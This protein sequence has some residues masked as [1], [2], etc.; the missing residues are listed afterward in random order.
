MPSPPQKPGQKI[1]RVRATTQARARWFGPRLGNVQAARDPWRCRPRQ[2]PGTREYWCFWPTWNVGLL[3]HE[4][5]RAGDLGDPLDE[6]LEDPH[7]QGRGG[8]GF[9][10]ELRADGEPVVAGAL[11]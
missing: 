7:V 9:G 3:G 5:H 2:E 8:L 4:L 1:N 10:V 11:D 6:L